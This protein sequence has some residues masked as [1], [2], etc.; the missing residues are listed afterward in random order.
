LTLPGTCRRVCPTRRH[1]PRKTF[2]NAVTPHT[3]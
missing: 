1:P 3:K 2:V